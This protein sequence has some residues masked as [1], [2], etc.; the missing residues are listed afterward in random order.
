M[1]YTT[2][3]PFEPVPATLHPSVTN[4]PY[5]RAN[6]ALG[7]ALSAYLETIRADRILADVLESYGIDASAA[8]PELPAE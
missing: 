6:A 5:T 8:D 7:D 4:Y 1:T 3:D 2:I